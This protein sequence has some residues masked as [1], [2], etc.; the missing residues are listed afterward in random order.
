MDEE[1]SVPDGD[2]ILRARGS[3]N[4]RDFRVHK[5]V[6]SLASLVFRDMFGIPQPRLN[7]PNVDIEV[8][9]MTDPPRAL[10]LVLR[11]IYP[12]PPPKVDNMD[13]LIEGLV[14]TD[15][16]DMGGARARLREPLNRF[17]KEAPLRVYAIASRFG[18]DEEAEAASSL[19]TDI[20][21]PALA[22]DDL[23]DD[24]KDVPASI[25]HKLIVLHEKHREEI[26]DAIDAV[27]F[28]PICP[29]CKLAKALAE[30]RMRTKLV[31]IICQGVPMSVAV[32]V[33]ELG[34]VCEAACMKKFIEDV[35]VGLGNK[36]AVIRS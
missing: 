35:I 20:F 11:L 1:F 24:F 30:P 5:L 22:N 21:L 23:P 16:Y 10:D 29:V 26:E 4:H 27:L 17:I 15:K 8:I 18:F 6:L 32:C 19:T 9:D 34:V 31:R 33:Q 2:I 7:V 28:L 14:I 36:N 13:L 3:P 25:Y 12:F